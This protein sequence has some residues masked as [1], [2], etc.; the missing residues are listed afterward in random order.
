MNGF[1]VVLFGV[2]MSDFTIENRPVGCQAE[3]VVGH[4]TEFG[5]TELALKVAELTVVCGARSFSLV[6]HYTAINTWDTHRNFHATGCKYALR[7]YVYQ[8]SE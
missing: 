1:P 5:S 3:A 2:I 4:N 7:R 8:L 6:R